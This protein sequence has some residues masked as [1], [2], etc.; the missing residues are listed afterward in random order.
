MLLDPLDRLDV[1]AY[2]RLHGVWVIVEEVCAHDEHCS[3]KLTV[4]PERLFVDKYVTAALLDQS[5]R[6]WLRSPTAIQIAVLERGKRVRVGS[7]N[8][9]N[10]AA[11]LLGGD[12][13]LLEP[14]AQ[15]N[16]LGITQL[17]ACNPLAAEL[18]R[19]GDV[20]FNDECGAAACRAGYDSHIVAV[21][22]DVAVDRRTLTDVTG[23]EFAGENR[24]DDVRPCIEGLRVDCHVRAEFLREDPVIQADQRDGVGYVGKIAKV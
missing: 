15:R 10:V 4:W 5:R 11:V 14:V 17:W 12:A 8:D 23:I 21:G 1:G 3:C 20:G 16:I 24:G 19:L 7:G 22:L 6:P 2:E 9:L 18:R 13:V